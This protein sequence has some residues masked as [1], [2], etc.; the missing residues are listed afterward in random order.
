M[1]YRFVLLI[2][3]AAAILFP[4]NAFAQDMDLSGASR[5]ERLT[6]DV[7]QQK[8][9]LDSA[10][11]I[12]IMS[13]CQLAQDK[14]RIIENANSNLVQERINTYNYIQDELQA[15]KVRMMRQGADASEADLMTG[16]IQ[17][18][19]DSFTIQAN[20]YGTALDDVVNVDCSQNPEQFE[21]GLIVMRIQRA[22]LLKQAENLKSL[23]INDQTDIFNPLKSRLTI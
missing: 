20:N 4:F 16:K 19:L 3:I 7:I 11:R 22:D 9:V 1:Q 13:R 14:L 12:M 10:T 21:A 18:A 17:S 15:I 6:E 2:L 8:V 5:D 23:F